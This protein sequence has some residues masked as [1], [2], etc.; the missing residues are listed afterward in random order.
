MKSVCMALLVVLFVSCSSDDGNSNKDYSLENQEEILSYIATNNIDA[1]STESG[2][3]YVIDEVGEGDAITVTSDVTVKYKG[4]FTDGTV[5]DENTESAVSFNLQGVIEGWQEGIPMFNEGGSGL[6]IIPAHLAYGSNSYGGIPAG[7]VLVF[8]IEI[9]DY[10]A[11]NNQEIEDYIAENDLNAMSTASGL[12]YV[13]EEQGEGVRPTS[14]STVTVN[15]EGYFTDGEIFAERSANLNLEI[16]DILEGWQEGLQ[17]L[18]EGGTMKLLI[19]SAL[20][21]GRYDYSVIPGGSV[22]IFDIEL[23]DVN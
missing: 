3:Y 9:I 13:I 5:F 10:N 11:I 18:N 15:Y 17:L 22:T 1:E 4:Y 12:Y 6:L 16:E 7:S 14:T 21:Y 2:L 20:G 19:P 8:E 23:V